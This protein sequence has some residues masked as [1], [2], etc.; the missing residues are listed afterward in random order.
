M[1]RQY[2]KYFGGSL[3]MFNVAGYGVDVFLRFPNISRGTATHVI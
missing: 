1:S 3:D 2:A